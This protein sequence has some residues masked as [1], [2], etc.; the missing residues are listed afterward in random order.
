MS[1]PSNRTI[2]QLGFIRARFRTRPNL[3]EAGGI[4]K[5]LK[6]RKIVLPGTASEVIADALTRAG[7]DALDDLS[8]IARKVADADT[9][10][11]EVEHLRGKP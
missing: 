4:V 5:I 11:R 6:C 2:T 8:K 3:G 1:G 10:M 7:E 9:F